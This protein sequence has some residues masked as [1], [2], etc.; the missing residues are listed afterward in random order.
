MNQIYQMEILSQFLYDLL[1]GKN[2]LPKNYFDKTETIKN[3]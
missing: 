2:V 3:M 1:I